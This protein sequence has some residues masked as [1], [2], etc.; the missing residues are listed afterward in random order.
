MKIRYILIAGVIA[1]TISIV[2]E[3]SA[4]SSG[5][6]IKNQ[7][8]QNSSIGTQAFIEKE[9]YDYVYTTTRVNIRVGAGEENEI[10]LTAEANTKLKRIELNAIQGW[11]KI[12]IGNEQ[13]YISNDFLTIEEPIEIAKSIEEQIE[14]SK[15]SST[16]LRYMSAIIYAEA[17][18]QC[19]A[20][21]QA[22][23]IVVMNRIKSE[24]YEDTVYEVIHEENQFTPVDDGNLNKALSIYD[25]GDFPEEIIEVAKYVLKGNTV[26]YYD[27]IAYNLDGYLYFSRYLE[28]CRL[29]IG[30]HSFK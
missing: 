19:K 27:D 26:V 30:Q 1:S 5:Q 4:K 20:G 7:L 6:N 28:D 10:L 13:Y 17:R 18:N 21:Q 23:G 9:A 22:V 3:L 12:S 24:L 11:D 8:S 2:P 16:D 29:K 15:I 25:S 14:D